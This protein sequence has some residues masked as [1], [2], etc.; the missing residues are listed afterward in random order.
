MATAWKCLSRSGTAERF[1]AATWGL[2][3]WML[4]IAPPV[5]AN[6]VLE[7]H[8]ISESTWPE[9]VFLVSPRHDSPVEQ[10]TRTLPR[11]EVR[12]NGRQYPLPPEQVIPFLEQGGASSIVLV[13]DTN[14]GMRPYFAALKETLTTFVARLAPQVPRA[15]LWLVEA[16]AEVRVRRADTPGE[17]PMLAEKIAL[18]QRPGIGFEQALCVAADTLQPVPAARRKLL[19]FVGEGP[20]LVPH[21][22]TP[23]PT[24]DGL[25]AAR[26]QRQGVPILVAAFS[27]TDWL[28]ADRERQET[29]LRAV[30][31]PLGSY[32]HIPAP[33][34]SF[35]QPDFAAAFRAWS[36]AV[37][38]ALLVTY[39]VRA[40]PPCRVDLQLVVDDAPVPAVVTVEAHEADTEHG[41]TI[42]TGAWIVLL[43]FSFLATVLQFRRVLKMTTGNQ[44]K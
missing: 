13:V 36:R 9:I 15:Q 12:E 22:G 31:G 43:G 19:F 28:G 11:V 18:Q 21:S 2:A 33:Q 44:R 25:C 29:V 26:L 37:Q 32:H 6:W 17:W 30:A 41:R 39:R 4:G 5:Q 10:R 20:V 7:H 40:T 38:E 23:S 16:G 42:R 14:P 8:S 1:R 3:F 35:S 34:D 27:P 24:G